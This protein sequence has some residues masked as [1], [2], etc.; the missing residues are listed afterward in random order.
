M[1]QY[2]RSYHCQIRPSGGHL[3]FRG[4][5]LLLKPGPRAAETPLRSE[6]LPCV[7]TSQGLVIIGAA[8]VAAYA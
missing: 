1:R 6:P 4:N 2:P 5:L 7:A 8:V 3:D